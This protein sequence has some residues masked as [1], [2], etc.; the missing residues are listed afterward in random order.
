MK[1]NYEGKLDDGTVFDSSYRR[2]EPAVFGLDRVIVCWSEAVPKLRMG[3][4]ANLTCPPAI[5]Y[6][7]RG[8]PPTIPA[9]AT[10]HFS[11]ELLGVEK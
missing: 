8:Q 7:D 11:L 4:K 2:G 9:N 5:A 1:V 6:G 3:A 10:L